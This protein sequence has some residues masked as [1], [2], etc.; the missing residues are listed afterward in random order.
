MK[1]SAL[2]TVAALS[3]GALAAPHNS[4]RQEWASVYTSCSAPNTIALTFD[5]GPYMYMDELVKTLTD[6][7]G[8]GTFFVNG[9]NWDCIY[10]YQDQLKRAY[11]A[12][13]QIASHTWSH[14]HLPELNWDQLH[15]EM[16]RV[17]LALERIL[18]VTPAMVRPPYGEYN[19]LV[20]QVA[21]VRGQA[22][23]NWDFDVQDATGDANRGSG[24]MRS[25][26][27]HLMWDI[28]PDNI[29]ALNHEVKEG[30]VREVIPQVVQW[31][32]ERGYKMVTVAECL[33]LQA[34]QK[35]AEPQ[36]NDVRISLSSS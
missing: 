14:K 34:Y 32:N 8:K 21:G 36:Q 29:L 11:A 3:L 35:V 30:T 25:D 19:D 27:G 5:D 23:V 17:E 7:G 16:W 1:F 9:Q 2:A 6:A 20:R 4:K 26:Y 31:A 24:D 15:D 12:G 22:I 28:R 18:G 13:M 33:G 10:N